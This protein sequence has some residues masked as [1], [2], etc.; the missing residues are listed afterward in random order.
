MFFVSDG[1]PTE[2]DGTD[3]IVNTPGDMEI[4]VW[5]QFITSKQIDQA[6]A[7]G[8]GNGV[9][10]GNLQPLAYPNGDATNPVVILNESELFGVL[11]GAL[12]GTVSG[13]VADQ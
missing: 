5:E 10:V 13:N 2:G 11:T 4:Q 6:F 3:G 12:P 7:V 8:V 1:E 9:N